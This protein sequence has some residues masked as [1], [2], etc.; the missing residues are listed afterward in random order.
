MMRLRINWMISLWRRMG[1]RLRLGIP[2]I[3]SCLGLLRFQVKLV[4]LRIWLPGDC[5][6]SNK[7]MGVVG[8][9]LWG[10]VGGGLWGRGQMR[11]RKLDKLRPLPSL[12]TKQWSRWIRGTTRFYSWMSPRFHSWMSPFLI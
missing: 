8:G 9:G 11:L 12:G 4:I 1:S 6:R 3:C 5:Q 10:I 7:H 2:R